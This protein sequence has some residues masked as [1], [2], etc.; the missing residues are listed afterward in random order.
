VDAADEQ[1]PARRRGWTA[2]ARDDR[3]TLYGAADHDRSPFSAL[4]LVRRDES[5]AQGERK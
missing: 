2:H 4:R 5:G 3:A 1:D